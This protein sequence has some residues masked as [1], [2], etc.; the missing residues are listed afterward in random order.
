[1]VPVCEM[2]VCSFMLMIV[3]YC[4]GSTFVYEHNCSM[5]LNGRHSL[6]RL[7]ELHYKLWGTDT[8]LARM[9]ALVT[10]KLCRWY[11]FIYK[12]IY[13]L[14]PFY[15]CTLIEKKM[16]GSYST[17]SQIYL[18]LSVPFAQTGKNALV[19]S[20][21]STCKTLQ[22]DR[23]RTEF[24]TLSAFKSK[25]KSLECNSR[26]CTCCF[27]FVLLFMGFNSI[28]HFNLFVLPWGLCCICCWL[29]AKFLLKN[30]LF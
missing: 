5:S 29:L 2:L 16:I 30:K 4:C 10:R 8:S 27:S 26:T 7:F 17:C 19:C 18:M 12:A 20:E 23:K 6:S 13:G 15:I 24:I 25:L 21:P 11:T 9:A 14:L 22:K 3:I 1:M 28:W